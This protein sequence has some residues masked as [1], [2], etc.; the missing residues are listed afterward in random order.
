MPKLIQAGEVPGLLSAGFRVF[1]QGG[2]GEPTALLSAIRESGEAGRGVRYFGIFPPGINRWDP[3]SFARDV[4]MTAFFGTPELKASVERG[5]TSLVPLHYSAI[6]SHL[7]DQAVM[8]IALIQVAP[9]DAEGMCSQGV[10]LDFGP[11]VLQRAKIVVAEINRAMPAPPGS[12]T[13]PFSRIDF[14]VE[15]DH[16]LV[17]PAD[18]QQDL[19]SRRLGEHVAMLVKDGDTIQT[20]MGRVPAAVLGALGGK[21]DLGFHSGLLT[22]P[23][24]QLIEA[25]VITGARKAVD[26]GVS[27]TGIAFGSRRFYQALGARRD[28]LFRPAVYTHSPEVLGRM[29]GF[30]AINS[31]IEVDLDGQVNAEFIKGRQISGV[32]G[33]VD[34]MRG[35]RLARDGRSVIAMDSRAGTSGR[36][37]IVPRVEKVTCA[38]SDVDFVATE[39]GVADLRCKCAEERSAALIEIAAP[40]FR[41]GLVE[42]FKRA[43]NGS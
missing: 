8:D 34:F 17:E 5:A 36:S 14:A 38:R 40:E 25:G 42:D 1:V 41:V 15:T 10:S 11:A 3:T 28:V 20:G 2:S 32:G 24:L 29:R 30:V 22:E 37:R 7:R 23:V 9:P 26:R 43:R 39:Y 19:V 35:A 27:V 13:I 18:E 31:A 4:T 21:N 12:P 16:P 33:L 6:Y